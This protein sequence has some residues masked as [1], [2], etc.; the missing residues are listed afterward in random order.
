MITLNKYF[1]YLHSNN[2]QIMKTYRATVNYKNKSGAVETVNCT[3]KADS[4]IDAERKMKAMYP[5]YTYI[6]HISIVG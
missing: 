5:T 1:R 6:G 4:P 2:S 3:V